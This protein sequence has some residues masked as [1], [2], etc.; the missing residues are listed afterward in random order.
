MLVRIT[1][2]EVRVQLAVEVFVDDELP[3]RCH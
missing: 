1:W 2:K 3:W